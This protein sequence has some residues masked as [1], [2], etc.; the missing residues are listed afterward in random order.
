[1][2]LVKTAALAGE[3]YGV[4]TLLRPP[5]P[6]GSAPKSPGISQLGDGNPVSFS[7]SSRPNLP[8]KAQPWNGTRYLEVF[9]DQEVAANQI[10]VSQLAI[11]LGLDGQEALQHDFLHSLLK[12]AGQRAWKGP[13]QEAHTPQPK[14]PHSIPTS[15]TVSNIQVGIMEV[16]K[17]G[18]SGHLRN[19]RK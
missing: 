11:Q 16:T 15:H 8:P 4:V 9:V 2:P 7:R 5:R 17:Y 19:G 14:R 12:E 6:P 13:S 10:E 18:L 3:L 1:M